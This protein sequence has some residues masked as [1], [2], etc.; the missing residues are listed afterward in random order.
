MYPKIPHAPKNKKVLKR[1]Q[2][3]VTVEI[4]ED[5]VWPSLAWAVIQKNEKKPSHG[6]MDKKCCAYGEEGPHGLA[7]VLR[8][9]IAYALSC[10]EIEEAGRREDA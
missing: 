1:L 7:E 6:Y 8:C 10:L 2:M 4:Y 9:S 3:S 5:G